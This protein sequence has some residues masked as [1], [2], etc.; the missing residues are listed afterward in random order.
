MRQATFKERGLVYVSHI[1]K[2]NCEDLAKIVRWNEENGIKVFRISSELFPWASEY[3]FDALPDIADIRKILS[4]T[5]EYANSVS[6]RLS[7][8]PGPFNCLASKN[9]AVV[10]KTVKE[11]TF[12]SQ[13]MDMLNQPQSPQAKINIHVGGAYGNRE[14]AAEEWCKNFALLPE[15]VQKRIT[16]ENDDKAS[17]FS[18]KMLY[19]WVY[20]RVG[21]PIVF[22]SHHFECGPQDSDYKE[23]IEMAASTW[24]ANVRPMCHHSNSRQLE[25]STAPRAAHSDYYYRAFDSCGIEVDV[26]LE[27][28]AKELGLQKY[29]ADFVNT[30]PLLMARYMRF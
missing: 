27:C 18:T 1:A 23:A 13:I 8:H 12:H 9:N 5:G 21:V 28:K 15:S 25:D 4:D 22:D 7:F 20:K 19:D 29:I 26:A 14:S 3:E 2:Q 6:Q 11:L 30:K 24:P 17:M 10:Q 16:V